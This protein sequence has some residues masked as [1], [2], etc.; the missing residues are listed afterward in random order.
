MEFNGIREDTLNA[1]IMRYVQAALWN[2]GATVIQLRELDLKARTGISGYPAWHEGSRE[3]AITQGLPSWIYNGSNNNYNSDIRTRPYMANYFGADILISLHNN[4]WNGTLTGTE[5]YWDTDNHPLSNALAHAVHNNLI[6]TIRAEYDPYWVDRGIKASDSGYGEINY[7]Q[8]PAILIELAFMDNPLDNAFL[9][10]ETSK[11]LAANAITQGICDFLGIT[12]KQTA[13]TLPIVLEAPTLMPTFGEGLCDSGWYRFPNQRAQYAYL[14]LNVTKEDQTAHQA[15][16]QPNL[17][18]SGEYQLE[19]FIPAHDAV[20]WL[21]PD[22][23]IDN[24]TRQAF[25]EIRHVNGLSSKRINQSALSNGWADLGIFYF[26]EETQ[27]SVMLRDIT[28]EPYQTTTISASAM[29]FTLVGKGGIPFHNTSWLV[30]TWMTEE[31]Q[32]PAEYIRNFFTLHHSCLAEPL[33]DVDQQVIDIPNLLY[34]AASTNQ[35]N[36]KALLAV[37]EAEQKAVSQCPDQAALGN[38]MGLEPATTARQQIAAAAAIFAKDIADLE[39]NGETSIGWGTG[40]PKITLDDVSVIPANDAITILFSYS[41]YAGELW[42]GIILDK[43]GVQGIYA[44]WREY[45]LS[46]PLPAQVEITYFPIIYR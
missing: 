13:L 39:K 8:M 26:N 42:G 16:W 40:K 18:V 14:G 11:L 9:H 27:A 5:T 25:Y 24:D 34:Q 15:T 41:Q 17:P 23:T 46:V 10:L 30:D 33:L 7:A 1:E 4:G 6:K 29:R 22:I 38:L 19:A 28:L 32:A 45:A 31:T 35:I 20:D 36:P 21:C 44:A 3:Y 37:M 2:Q 12:C 43:S